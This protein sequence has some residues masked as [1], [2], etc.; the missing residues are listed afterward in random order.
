[1]GVLEPTRGRRNC[2][3]RVRVGY[4]A[5]HHIDALGD[6]ELSSLQLIR[7]RFPGVQRIQLHR[8]VMFIVGQTEDSYR[9]QLARFGVDASLAAQPIVWLSGGQKSRLAFTLLAADK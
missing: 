3:R 4:F 1:M 8:C 9:S 2:N 5:Q 6:M 7:Q